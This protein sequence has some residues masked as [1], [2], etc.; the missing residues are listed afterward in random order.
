MVHVLDQQN[1]IKE[2]AAPSGGHDRNRSF[3]IIQWGKLLRL[4]IRLDSGPRHQ[5]PLVWMMCHSTPVCRTQSEEIK[6]FFGF[7][8]PTEAW[9]I[10]T[11]LIVSVHIT[12]I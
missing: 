2:A 1:R 6:P 12:I 9:I 5:L 3:T 11:S 4:Q 7:N 10:A 8:L